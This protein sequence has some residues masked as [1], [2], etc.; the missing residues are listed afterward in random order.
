MRFEVRLA[1]REVEQFESR[2]ALH[3]DA[4]ALVRITQH[5]KDAHRG[6]AL[7]HPLGAGVFLFRILLRSQCDYTIALADAI[8]EL[9]RRRP[10]DQERMNLA[11]K[12]YD[13]AQWE[14]RQDIRNL[15]L[16]QI[17]FNVEFLLTLGLI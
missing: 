1:L 6:G 2:E 7:I 3:Q 5:L 15:D 13:P 12:N 8:Y 10:G 4:Y 17:L 11:G 9:E 16:A 14:Y